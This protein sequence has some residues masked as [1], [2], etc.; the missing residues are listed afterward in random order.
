M[1]HPPL[2]FNDDDF[3]RRESYMKSFAKHLHNNKNTKVGTPSEFVLLYDLFRIIA[4]EWV[5]F[6]TYVERELN[7]IERWF[8]N[9]QELCPNW[10]YFLNKLMTI[11]RRLTKY[12]ILV[13]NQLRQCPGHW[14]THDRPQAN[15]PTASGRLHMSTL[16]D[17]DQVLDSFSYNQTRNSEAIKVATSLM[18][19][20]LNSLVYKQTRYVGIQTGAVEAQTKRVEE[21]TKLVKEQTKQ[22]V[23]QESVI[24]KQNGLAEARNAS[25]A[26]LTLVTSIFLPFTTVAAAMSIP[27]ETT[28]RIGGEDQWKFWVSASCFVFVVFV[29]FACV[30]IY[31]DRKAKQ[32]AMERERKMGGDR[33]ANRSC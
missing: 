28:W 7:N 15:N 13:R 9:Y 5:V 25:L 26:F 4:S 19:V 23:E 33:M 6:N 30:T 10:H 14:N 21:Q 24:A 31:Y 29:S 20:W 32:E 1:R 8:E 2:V 17:F 12:E 16:M 27:T 3:D 22:V 18:T 11:R